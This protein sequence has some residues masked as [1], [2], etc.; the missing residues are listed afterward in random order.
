[1]TITPA[2]AMVRIPLKSSSDSDSKRPVIPIQND[3]RSERSDAGIFYLPDWSFCRNGLAS[4]RMDSPL[5][6][7][8]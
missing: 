4:F 7:I 2:E 8:L 1:M 6:A 3:H 5:N